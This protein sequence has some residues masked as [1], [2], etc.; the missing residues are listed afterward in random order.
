MD[1]RNRIDYFH[2]FSFFMTIYLLRSP[3][4]DPQLKFEK[5]KKN[6]HPTHWNGWL[7]AAY[8]L[9]TLYFRYF[10]NYPNIKATFENKHLYEHHFQNCCSKSGAY[11]LYNIEQIFRLKIIWKTWLTFGNILSFFFLITL[12][13]ASM[14][15]TKWAWASGLVGQKI[16]NRAKSRGIKFTT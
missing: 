8:S 10:K 3:T 5:F 14:T 12:I 1:K 2:Y 6:V 16:W 11:R 7:I 9:K 4:E 15:R 13:K